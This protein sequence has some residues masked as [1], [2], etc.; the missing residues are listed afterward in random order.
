MNQIYYKL[1]KRNCL[2]TQIYN[3]HFVLATLQKEEEE[4]HNQA[5]SNEKSIAKEVKLRPHSSSTRK[6]ASRENVSK[7]TI[8][9]VFAKN[10]L[11]YKSVMEVTELTE[12]QKQQRLNY[13]K[14]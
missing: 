10:E 6:L 11:E 13:E 9:K 5:S 4:N 8:G 1:V 7:T 12:E 14:Y 2:Q 3:S